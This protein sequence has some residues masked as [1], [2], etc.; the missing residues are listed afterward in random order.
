MNP[1]ATV[2]FPNAKEKP[3]NAHVITAVEKISI[4]YAI[5]V[6]MFFLSAMPPKKRPKPG[7]TRV[8]R[9]P[10][11]RIQAVLPESIVINIS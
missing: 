10:E 9:A 7:A 2:E 6:K 3:N 8:A 11:M 4:Q 1:R 5:V